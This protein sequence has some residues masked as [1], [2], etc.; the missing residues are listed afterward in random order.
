MLYNKKENL[1]ERPTP[2]FRI[3]GATTDLFETILSDF[4]KDPMYE[5]EILN[6]D[7]IVIKK[8]K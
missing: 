8:R 5:V 1:K 4:Q 7:E 3:Q 6:R 2:N